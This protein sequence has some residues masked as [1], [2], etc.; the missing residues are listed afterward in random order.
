MCIDPTRPWLSGAGALDPAQD[1]FGTR[2]QTFYIKGHTWGLF[3]A[4]RGPRRR[5]QVLHLHWSGLGRGHGF[6]ADIVRQTA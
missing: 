4:Y 5:R 2:W 6:A 1:T 3:S